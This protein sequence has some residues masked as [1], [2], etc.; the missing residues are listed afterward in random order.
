MT[1][2]ATAR[3]SSTRSHASALAT[4]A[5]RLRRSISNDLF[6]QD[7]V[8]ERGPVG[9]PGLERE[10]KGSNGPSYHHRAADRGQSA[11]GVPFNPFVEA[12]VLRY[13]FFYGPRTSLGAGGKQLDPICRPFVPILGS[14]AGI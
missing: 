11:V 5:R 14:S 2:V 10:P 3:P 9:T 13:G 8:L 6:R 12:I 7:H 4:G 1:L